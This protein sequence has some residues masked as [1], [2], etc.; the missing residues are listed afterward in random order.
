MIELVKSDTS[1]VMIKLCMDKSMFVK[2]CKSSEKQALSSKLLSFFISLSFD[3][4]C[5][6]IVGQSFENF[7]LLLCFIDSFN[8]LI[9]LVHK[10]EF[11]TTIATTTF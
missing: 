1:S 11:L 5:C 4:V 6:R 10:F 8:F 3:L 2:R 9:V 7:L